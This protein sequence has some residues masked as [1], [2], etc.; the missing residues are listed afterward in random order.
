MDRCNVPIQ[1]P[2]ALDTVLGVISARE[3]DRIDD[4]ALL[5]SGYVSDAL[6][7]GQSE[8]AA[9]CQLFSQAVVFAHGQLCDIAVDEDIPFDV[10]MA[11]V[12]LATLPIQQDET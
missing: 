10:L 4:A 1:Y 11:E 9:Y 6:A 2:D 12:H 3:H 8:A 7:S 5:I